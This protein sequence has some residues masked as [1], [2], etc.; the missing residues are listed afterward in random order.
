MVLMRGGHFLRRLIL[1]D[2]LL[3]N[4]VSDYIKLEKE[5]LERHANQ[6]EKEKHSTVIIERH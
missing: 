5:T 1:E 4:K 6:R 3:P 2:A